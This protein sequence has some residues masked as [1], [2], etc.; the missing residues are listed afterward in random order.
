MGTRSVTETPSP[1]RQPT[2]VS[3]GTPSKIRSAVSNEIPRW[4]ALAAIQR[5]LPWTAISQR[6]TNLPRLEPD[7]GN[8]RQ[9]LVTDRDHRGRLDRLF[10]SRSSSIAPTGHKRSVAQLGDGGCG[11]ED[12]VAGQ[13]L[14]LLVELGAPPAAQRGTEDARVDGKSHGRIAAAKASSSTSVRSSINNASAD[15]RAGAAASCSAVKSRGSRAVPCGTSLRSFAAV[16]TEPIVVPCPTACA[17]AV[18]WTARWSIS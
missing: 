12:L 18:A 17:A 8:R 5:S 3:R 14:D 10:Q 4:T 11:E 2:T 16:L 9:E 1:T 15:A 6:V 13:E 7:L